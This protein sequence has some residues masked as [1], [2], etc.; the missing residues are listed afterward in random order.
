MGFMVLKRLV[1]PGLSADKFG[2]LPKEKK[3]AGQMLR[4]LLKTDDYQNLI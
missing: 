2:R 4:R 1:E 3:A